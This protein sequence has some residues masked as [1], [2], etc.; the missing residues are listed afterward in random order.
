MHLLEALAQLDDSNPEHFTTEG[1]PR[2]DVVQRLTGDDTITRAD[3]SKAGRVRQAK[4]ATPKGLEAVP[5]LEG[6]LAA[7]D[8]ADANLQAARARVYKLE[9]DLKARNAELA[10]VI[11]EWQSLP[12]FE[13]TA[14]DVLRANLKRD[15][16]RKLAIAEGRAQPDPVPVAEVP[17]EL[18]A[19]LMSRRRNGARRARV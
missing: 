3:I 8:C 13:R 12:E 17:S 19:A 7:I 2:V 10:E 4:R 15:W 18:D 16:D 14:E 9:A 1:L 5:T 6:S 11:V